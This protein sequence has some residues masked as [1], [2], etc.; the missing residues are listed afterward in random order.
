MTEPIP[1][2]GDNNRLDLIQL[3]RL[4]LSAKPHSRHTAGLDQGRKLFQVG[5]RVK[6]CR[7]LG[8]LRSSSNGACSWVFAKWLTALDAVKTRER[9]AGNERDLNRT[10]T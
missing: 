2:S 6:R 3:M 10:E 1:S 8:S 7:N 9:T 4:P 5:Y